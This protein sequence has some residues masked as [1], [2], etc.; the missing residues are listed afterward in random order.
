M[1]SATAYVRVTATRWVGDEPIPGLVEVRLQ[2]ANGDTWQFIDKAPL[3]DESAVLTRDTAYPVDLDV[4]CTVRARHVR[5]GRVLF[6]ISTASPWGLETVEGRHLFEVTADQVAAGAR[7]YDRG[8]GR[9][10]DA[11]L[12]PGNPLRV[13]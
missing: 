1:P 10:L 11:I 5:D 13:D 6:E 12:Q 9:S 4:A 8:T 3:F 7:Q 2:D